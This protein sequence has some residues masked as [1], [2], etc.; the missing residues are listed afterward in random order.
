M[1]GHY[2][3][4]GDG[5]NRGPPARRS[6]AEV[7]YGAPVAGEHYER[8]REILYDEQGRV[9]ATRE[10]VLRRR[11][12]GAPTTGY[13]AQGP[14][15]G[16]AARGLLALIAGLLVLILKLIGGL[17]ALTVGFWAGVIVTY[18]SGANEF[19]GAGIVL[20]TCTLALVVYAWLLPRGKR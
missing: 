3:R 13:Y 6:R 17:I 20:L 2:L 15:A 4:R 18:L 1:S 14:S 7:A 9:R 5:E 11:Q 8:T 10:H 12:M 19:Q 16:E